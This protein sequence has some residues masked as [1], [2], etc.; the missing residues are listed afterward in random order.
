MNQP[1]PLIPQGSM[2][3]QKQQSR[4]RVKVAFFCVV[5]AHVAVIMVALLAQGCKREQ[6]A[7]QMD[8]LVTDTYSDTNTYMSDAPLTPY[9]EP[10][11]APP[12]IVE[13][14]YV[15]PEPVPVQPAVNEHVIQKGDTFYSLAKKYAVTMKSIQDANPAVDPTKLKIGQKIVIPAPTTLPAPAGT[16][17]MTASGEQIYVV[18]SGDTLSSIAGRYHV[19]VKELR[20]ANNLTTDRIYV[21]QKLKIPGSAGAP[22]PVPTPVSPTETTPPLR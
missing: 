7:P 9:M 16:T 13:Q 20:A 22:A 4:S 10:T 5:G 11:S 15:A 14:P 1:S 18:K 3:E 17:T 2:M 8:A 19:T 6:P 21:D 12:P